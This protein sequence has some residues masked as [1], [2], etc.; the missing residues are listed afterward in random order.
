MPEDK[1][2]PRNRTARLAQLR[3]AGN[4]VIAELEAG[5][6]NCFPGL[7]VDL[8]NLDRRFFPFLEV[9]FVRPRI[10]VVAV[11]LDRAERDLPEGPLLDGLRQ[12]AAAAGPWRAIRIAG[13]FTGFG[14]RTFDLGALGLGPN[15]PPDAWTA[16]RLLR[17]GTEVE[18][19]LARRGGAAV[20]VA[21]P[22][23]SYLSD[24]GAFAPMFEPGELTQSLCSP[25]TH[26]FRDC[27]CF[28]W[29]SNHPALV[30]PGVPPGVRPD[31]PDWGVR[32][33]WMRSQRPASVPPP[34]SPDHRGEMAYFEINERWQDLDVVLD[35]REQ[36]GPYQPKAVAGTPLSAE[37]LVPTLRYAAGVEIG[38]M[39]EYLSAA[40]SVNAVAGV[41]G[42]ELRQD[43]RAARQQLLLVAFGE[44]R[45]LREINALLADMHRSSGADPFEPALGIATVLP[46]SGEMP[47]R[48][49]RF[50]RLTPEA[51][52]DFVRIEAPSLTVDGLYSSILATFERDGPEAHA[53]AIRSVMAEGADHYATFLAVQEWLGRHP[54]GSYLLPLGPAP[55][56]HPALRAV[57][58]RYER[59]LGLLHESYRAGIP[60]GAATIA[61]SRQVMLGPDGL[62][63]ACE[64]L[65]RQGFLPVFA[66]PADP[67]F[68]A[69]PP[70]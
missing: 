16:V 11:L 42:S 14:T 53:D 43:A 15:A 9:D 37:K 58:E 25:W 54:P 66:V 59:V 32:A 5:V 33:S 22:R 10:E 64:A 68:A 50:R 23:T 40:F 35:G 46:P 62:E 4:T 26:D 3:A 67:R 12:L 55:P 34:P 27:G 48:D 70:P 44:M 49:L 41:A 20:T 52:A 39:L 1:L 47:G 45:H 2:L 51:L 38:V 7:E 60:A 61:V 18:L 24:D 19:T 21:A 56:D 65:A 28:Y 30:L 36:R 63:G 29:A 69:V 13:T 6:G 31:D 8:R 17:P 57:Q